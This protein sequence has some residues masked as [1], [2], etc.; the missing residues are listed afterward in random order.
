M[1]NNSIEEKKINKLKADNSGIEFKG[2]NKFLKDCLEF[3][4]ELAKQD[5]IVNEWLIWRV[6][7]DEWKPLGSGERKEWKRLNNTNF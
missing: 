1:K 5:S 2:S 3:L 4:I 7:P 6:T